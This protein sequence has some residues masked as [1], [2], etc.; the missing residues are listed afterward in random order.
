MVVPLYFVIVSLFGALV[1]LTR[2]V[3]EYQGRLGAN[4]VNALAPAQAREYLVFQIMQLVSAPLLASTA[5][6][7]FDPGSRAGSILLAFTAGFASETIL[8][9][10]R[11]LATK[12]QPIGAAST[13]VIVTPDNIDF[14]EVALNKRSEPTPVALTNRSAAIVN[15]TN[16]DAT[17]DFSVI[18][19]AAKTFQIG[20]GE[21]KTLK[22]VFEPKKDG[23]LTGIVTVTDD[24]LGSPRLIKLSGVGKK[25]NGNDGASG[26]S[27]VP[28]TPQASQAPQ[29]QSIS[30]PAALASLRASPEE[31]DFGEQVTNTISASRG[32]RLTHSGPQPLEAEITVAGEFECEPKGPALLGAQEEVEVTFKPTTVGTRTGQITIRSG[33]AELSIPLKGTAT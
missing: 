32:V 4:A 12:L 21:T 15:V 16:V 28:V 11:A 33:P 2:R 27:G 1:S 26:A 6:Y 30:G 24:G 22:I 8:L 19:P 13:A 9:S 29:A 17:G 18:E 31:I 7:L 20:V 14:G 25:M 23:P 3:P 10:I 5:Y